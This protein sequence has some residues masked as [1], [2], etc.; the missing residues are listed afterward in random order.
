MSGNIVDGDEVGCIGP[1]ITEIMNKVKICC[2]HKER[3]VSFEKPSFT[4][5][6]MSCNVDFLKRF[7]WIHDGTVW[8]MI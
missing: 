7:R 3:F 5:T 8:V 4:S 1:S 6:K 2:S